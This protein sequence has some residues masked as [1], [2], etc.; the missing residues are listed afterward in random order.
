MLEV[1]L[2]DALGSCSDF[3]VDVIAD[4]NALSLLKIS[5]LLPRKTL[6][7]FGFGARCDAS[8]PSTLFHLTN[9]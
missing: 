1:P 3:E 5:G 7:D 2:N 9:E 4:V 6:Q 8:S